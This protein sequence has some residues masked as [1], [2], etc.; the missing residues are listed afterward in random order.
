MNHIWRVFSYFRITVINAP[1]SVL[2][3]NICQSSHEKCHILKFADLVPGPIVE[4]FIQWCKSSFLIINVSKTK[5]MMIDFRKSSAA[6]TPLLIND[7]AVERVQQH[8]YLSAM[9]T[10]NID[11]KD[12]LNLN[13]SWGEAAFFKCLINHFKEWW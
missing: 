11:N 6:T 13:L 10:T 1:C 2:Y 5:E 7:Q 3:T 4:E 8:K 12:I 9:I